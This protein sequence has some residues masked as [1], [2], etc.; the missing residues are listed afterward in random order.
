MKKVVLFLLVVLIVPVRAQQP[1]S[2][3]PLM[4]MRSTSDAALACG[5]SLHT[6]E[7]NYGTYD[8]APTMQFGSTSAPRRSLGGLPENP[9]E[10]G[11]GGSGGGGSLGELGD[12]INPMEPGEDAPIGEFPV[13]ALSALAVTYMVYK[14][15]NQK[16]QYQTE[17]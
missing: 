12:L 9:E 3:M 4:N 2:D 16:T 13:L 1:F 14:N 8:A 10:P 17:Q 6:A 11:G 15:R 7:A 5:S